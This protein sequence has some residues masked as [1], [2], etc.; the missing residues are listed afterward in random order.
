MIWNLIT[1]VD[2]TGSVDDLSGRGPKYTV[3]TDTVVEPVWQRV[4]EN[5]PTSTRRLAAQLG[6][7]RK[8]LQKILKLDLKLFLCEIQMVQTF[9]IQ[10][11]LQYL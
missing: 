3:Y 1:W 4:L 11:P 6:I 10:D 2:R 7:A 8:S 5:P 9:P